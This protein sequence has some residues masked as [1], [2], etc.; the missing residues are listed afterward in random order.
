MDI[1]LIRNNKA[2]GYTEGKLYINEVYFCDTLEDTDRGLKQSMSEQQIKS[3][4]VYGETAIPTGIYRVI[5][6]F[7]NKFKKI[8]PQLVGVKGFAGTRMHS[9][10]TVADSLG[11][12]LC[13]IRCGNGVIGNSR[14]TCSK[15]YDMIT[16]AISNGEDVFITIQ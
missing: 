7:S 12:V 13:G 6:T 11:C 9:G 5:M 3:I 14:T 8:L 15:L 10:N 4:K 16:D 1:S 2:D